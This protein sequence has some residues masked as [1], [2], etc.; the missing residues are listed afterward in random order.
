MIISE[1]VRLLKK[2]VSS[3]IDAASAAAV[4]EKS[5]EIC[6]FLIYNGY[7]IELVRVRNKSKKWGSYAFYENEIRLLEK[8][9]DAMGHE[10]VG[11]FHSHPYG[12]SSP[13]KSDILNTNDSSYMIIIDVTRKEFG[14][15]YIQN[16]DKTK[17]EF[18]LLTD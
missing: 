11:T 2:Q 18:D 15:W 9:A 13:S 6:G 5:A 8:A 4:D 10:I 7:F 17:V 3:V 1:N 14:L 16:N 12:D